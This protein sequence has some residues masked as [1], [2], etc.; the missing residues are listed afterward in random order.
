VATSPE[1]AHAER[2]PLIRFG[3]FQLELQSG[4][5]SRNGTKNR[6]QGQPLQLLELLL[7]HPGR[8]VTREEIQQHLWPD[9]VVVEFEH[10]VNAAVK[11]LRE[12]LSD[13][14]EN[15]TFIETIPRRGYRFIA[16]LT[17]AAPSG[18]ST[19]PL[20]LASAETVASSQ[21]SAFSDLP[22][23]SRPASRH[24]R[25]VLGGVAVLAVLAAGLMLYQSRRATG[26]R[27]PAVKS[28]AVLPLKNLSGD[29]TQEYFADGMTEEL[30]G[31]LSMIRGL[32]VISRTSV[33]GFKDTGM[34]ARSPR[35]CRSM[36]WSRA[37]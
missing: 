36:L 8:L 14:A 11:R 6:L 33:M 3:E 21:S 7:R 2:P 4:E 9:G 12:A 10:S 20:T 35:C 28:L 37:R 17:E 13:S 23:T 32:R 22:V 31:R 26:T 15:P 16:P 5:L 25:L 1:S 19:P 34:I 18:P 27:Q 24:L 29:P 30:I